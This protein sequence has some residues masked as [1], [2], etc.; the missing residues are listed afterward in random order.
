MAKAITGFSSSF[1]NPCNR[2]VVEI[3]KENRMGFQDVGEAYL[4]QEEPIQN[5][6]SWPTT[7]DMT[8]ALSKVISLAEQQPLTHG[9]AVATLSGALAQTLLKSEHD[10]KLA[11][12]SG[13]LHDIGIL[14]LLSSL[15]PEQEALLPHHNT[16]IFQGHY[17]KSQWLEPH[18]YFPTEILS[19]LHLDRE[20]IDWIKLHHCFINK[21]GLLPKDPPLKPPTL[22]MNIVTF[23]HSVIDTL[24][25]IPNS[26]QRYEKAQHFLSQLPACQ[27]YSDIVET[28]QEQFSTPESFKLLDAR[29][30]TTHFQSLYPQSAQPILLNGSEILH[31]C[32]WISNQTDA[33]QGKYTQHEGTLTAQLM[34]KMGKRLNLPL[35]ELG[36]LA[37]AG[38]LHDVGKL[39]IPLQ[40]LNQHRALTP[41]NRESIVS[42]TT[43]LEEII[44]GIPGFQ[45][46]G[47]W[48]GAHHECLNGS[49]YPYGRR[50]HEIPIGARM[51]AI[52]DTYVALTQAR[53]FRPS[54]YRPKDALDILKNQQGRIFDPSLLELLEAS[55]L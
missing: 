10:Q 33:R 37:L 7:L 17:E 24:Y 21:T 44:S 25:H 30:I 52:A 36:Q 55:I 43:I 6:G 23:S 34:V 28:F 15:S 41:Q 4:L 12:Q 32:Q 22:G 9:L 48:V 51:L 8:I 47:Q 26:L 35:H 31:L 42:H 18:L 2:M 38:L 46:I 1:N 11:M 40:V 20:I 13:L 3:S 39:A 14:P 27:F 49:G 16:A 45:T 54:A 19:L 5:A 50:R 53:P 29:R